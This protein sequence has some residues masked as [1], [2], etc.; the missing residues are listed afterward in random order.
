[1][2]GEASSL[3]TTCLRDAHAGTGLSVVQRFAK[4][5]LGDRRALDARLRDLV[6]RFRGAPGG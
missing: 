4:A 3:V 1:M 5:L 6:E 2:A